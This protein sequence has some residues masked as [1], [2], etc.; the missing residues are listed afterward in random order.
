MR[1]GAVARLEAL[2]AQLGH[3]AVGVEL[4]ALELLRERERVVSRERAVERPAE[5]DRG[6]ARLAQELRGGRRPVDSASAMPYAAASPIAGAPRTA[7]VRMHSATCAGVSHRIHV[8]SPG[9]RRW[10]STSRAPSSQRRG[11][12][13]GAIAES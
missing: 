10:S 2:R 11:A 13:S 5:V 9:S 4:V 1:E 12:I 3:A 8:S 6:R 7:S